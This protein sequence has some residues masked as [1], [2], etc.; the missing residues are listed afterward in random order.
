MLEAERPQRPT[1][2]V[3]MFVLVGAG[4]KLHQGIPHTLR[5]TGRSVL[6]VCRRKKAWLA[7]ERAPCG[8]KFST[9]KH[10]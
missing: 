2:A 4:G 9:L 6:W 8:L 10:E 7:R 3:G 5:S 1:C